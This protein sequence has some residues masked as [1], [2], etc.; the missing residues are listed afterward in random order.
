[1]VKRQ[2]M[3]TIFVNC[4]AAHS[5]QI[6]EIPET[7]HFVCPSCSKQLAEVG[8][9]RSRPVLPIV[10]TLG[11]VSIVAAFLLLHKQRRSVPAPLATS[12]QEP[13]QTP[14][15]I[16]LRVPGSNTIGAQL[17]PSLAEQYLTE[18]GA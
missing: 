15:I 7:A 17:M 2:G 6:V 5:K 12:P 4:A 16:I 8:S 9:R 18:H 3:C 1:M 13:G 14:N 10:I 11:L